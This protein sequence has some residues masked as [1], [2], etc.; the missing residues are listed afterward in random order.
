MST[1]IE[2]GFWSVSDKVD[3]M[4]IWYFVTHDNAILPFL[5]KKYK[6]QAKV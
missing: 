6:G 3:V 4:S 2:E 1:L 5:R